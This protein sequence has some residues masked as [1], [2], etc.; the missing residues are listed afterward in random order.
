MPS[1]EVV[2]HRPAVTAG[3]SRQF[4]SD[5][6]SCCCCHYSR[7]STGPH[8]P[9]CE[10][11]NGDGLAKAV[12]LQAAGAHSIHDGRVVDDTHRD[13]QGAGTQLQVGVSGGAATGQGYK[14]RL[15][16]ISTLTW[17]VAEA[18]KGAS[19]AGGLWCSAARGLSLTHPKGSP[20]TRKDTSRSLAPSKI[21]SASCTCADGRRWRNDTV[22][23]PR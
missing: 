16:G 7:C 6:Q 2:Q 14:G 8:R 13:A 23:R 19:Q 17:Q 22:A 21:V 12:Q 20:T 18:S 15:Q 1:C 3:S 10:E 11:H 5:L 9:T 4:K